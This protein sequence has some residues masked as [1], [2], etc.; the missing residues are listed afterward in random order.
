MPSLA[1]IAGLSWVCHLSQSNGGS[2][3]AFSQKIL[4]LEE[5]ISILL[6]P[7]YHTHFVFTRIFMLNSGV[8]RDSQNATLV[9][10]ANQPYRLLDYQSDLRSDSV[11][12]VS[13]GR[14]AEWSEK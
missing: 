5:S 1:I 10:D 2:V 12:F 8:D 7:K 3:D 9:R 6:T 14:N 4:L 11:R 13:L